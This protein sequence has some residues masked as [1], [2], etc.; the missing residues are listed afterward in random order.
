MFENVIDDFKSKRK[1]IIVHSNADTDAVGSA[2]AIAT[3]FGNADIYAP[4]G[5]DR[6]LKS[7]S[8]KKCFIILEKCDLS[9]Y[10]LVVVVDTSSPEQ[11]GIRLDI[12]RN[13]VIIDHHQWSGKWDGYRTIVD[14]SKVSCTQLILELIEEANIEI[15]R[16]VG[17]ML[18]GGMLTDSGHFQYSNPEMLRDFAH[19]LEITGL[20]IDE[21]IDLTKND[22]SVSER[23]ATIKCVERSKFERIGD[24]I[25]A[26]SYG[27]SYEASGCRILIQAGADVSFVASQRDENFRLSARATQEAVRRGV[28]LGKIVKDIGLETTTDGGGHSGAA[29]LSGVGDVEAMLHICTE[30]TLEEFRMIKKARDAMHPS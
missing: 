30:R 3:C 8:E 20:G 12:P 28:N 29:G 10:E 19:I 18:L 13:A 26:T 25:V 27:G 17:L 22:V 14:D 21:V 5:L 4:A 16:D 23:I 24:M 9:D 7:I 6:T 15:S 1:V 2:Y 11:F